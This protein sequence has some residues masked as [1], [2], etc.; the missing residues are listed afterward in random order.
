ATQAEQQIFDLE[1][2]LNIIR[3]VEGVLNS[4]EGYQL[5]PA[6]LRIQ[7]GGISGLISTYNS[8]V[9]ERNAFLRTSTP[10]NPVVATITAQLESLKGNLQDNINSTV[11]SLNIQ[12]NQLGQ[13]ERSAQG[14]FSTFPGMEKG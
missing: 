2:Q 3:S 1:M 4:R 11:N 14:K 8:L 9:L 10:E 7:A 5:L 13:L 6:N 12:L